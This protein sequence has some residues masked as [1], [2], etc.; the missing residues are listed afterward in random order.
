MEKTKQGQ[1]GMGQRSLAQ[2]TWRRFKRNRLCGDLD[3][4]IEQIDYQLLK[5]NCN[6]IQK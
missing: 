4:I 3:R 5:W 1:V 2:E 6:S